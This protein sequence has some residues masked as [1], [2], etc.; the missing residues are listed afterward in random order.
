MPGDKD[1]VMSRTASSTSIQASELS[2]PVPM[3]VPI[4]QAKSESPA[5][6][7]APEP[8][9]TEAGGTGDAEDA[10]GAEMFSMHPRSVYV[11][12]SEPKDMS[13]KFHW[14]II[15]ARS[16]KEGILYH[17]VFDGSQWELQI[18]ENKNIPA[19]QAVIL[20]LRVGD[21]PEVSPQWI[22]AIQ[23]CITAVNIPRTTMGAVTCRTFVL[24]VAYELGNGGFI[25]LYPNWNTVKGIEREAYQF[26]RHAGNLGRRLVVASQWSEL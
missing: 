8:K 1:L 26:A 7:A 25:S 3:P 2:G 17:R 24:A 15:I 14:G 4:T 23:E 18:E 10:V 19:D 22:T 6:D 11:V 13:E 21:V 5:P 12:V 20:L 16:Q 9:S